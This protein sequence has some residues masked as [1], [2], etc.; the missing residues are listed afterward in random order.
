MLFQVRKC[1][2]ATA[3]VQAEGVELE[4]A[5]G[6]VQ[7]VRTSAPTGHGL[8]ELEEALLLQAR[9]CLEFSQ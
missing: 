4:S 3:D 9:A 1:S 2:I 7:L 8:L 6:A 5:G